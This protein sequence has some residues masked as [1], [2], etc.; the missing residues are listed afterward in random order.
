[1][2]AVRALA[3]HVSE[4]PPLATENAVL[5]R[6]CALGFR[7]VARMEERNP[8]FVQ[9]MFARPPASLEASTERDSL[10]LRVSSLDAQLREMVDQVAVQRLEIDRLTG[11][12]T[13]HLQQSATLTQ[14]LV[15]SGSAVEQARAALSELEGQLVQLRQERDQQAHWHQENSRWAHSLKTELEQSRSELENL[16]SQREQLALEVRRAE[17]QLNWLKDVL[18]DDRR[19]QQAR[20]TRSKPSA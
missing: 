3:Q 14:A 16:R 15:E 5:A 18:L 20:R 4:A 8:A 12:E 19:R 10:A 2:V 17:E 7:C 6:L 13:A 9:L 11:Q 1:M